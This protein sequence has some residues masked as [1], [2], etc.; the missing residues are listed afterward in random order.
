M[1]AKK[2]SKKTAS[3][4]AARRAPENADY[5]PAAN[6]NISAAFSALDMIPPRHRGSDKFLDV[7][8][9]NIRYFNH[10]DPARVTQIAD[11]LEVLNADVIV[12]QEIDNDALKPVIEL[13]EVRGA[14]Y[15]E[16]VYGTAGGNQRVAIMWDYEWIRA[17]ENI[18][19]LFGKGAVVT[20]A[21]KD[22]FPRLP[23]H[24]YFTALTQ[25]AD[26]PPFTFQLVGLHLKSQMGGG[27]SQR[28]LAADWL[29]HWLKHEAPY[30]DAD[31]IMFGDWNKEPNAPEWAAIHEMEDNNEVFFR[32][33][34]DSSD[35]SHLYYKNKSNLGSR[36]DL[37]LVT[38][39]ANEAMESGANV[40]RWTTLDNFLSTNPTAAAIKAT[41]REIREKV[42]DHMPVVTR[43]YFTD[44]D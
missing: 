13:L 28:R 42:S 29:A 25:A 14:G 6:D 24:S 15:Y 34:N 9:W 31:V 36:L 7:V 12:L 33:I 4:A 21:N 17:K 8:S 18:T 16:V 1:S 11:I 39:S 2:A 40:V 26:S 44:E 30:T 23:L 27:E 10:R 3:K 32:K 41:L 20:P 35:F 43:F 22:A 19:E 37:A 5:E 38:T